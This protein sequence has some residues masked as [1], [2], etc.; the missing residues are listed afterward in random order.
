MKLSKLLAV[1]ALTIFSLAAFDATA[2]AE[3]RTVKSTFLQ[4]RRPPPPHP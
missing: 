2:G 1:A 4:I 3:I